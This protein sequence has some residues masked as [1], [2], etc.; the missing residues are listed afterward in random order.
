MFECSLLE[1]FVLP[2]LGLSS[3]VLIT[4]KHRGCLKREGLM[5]FRVEHW[6]KH[7]GG[8]TGE[9]GFGLLCTAQRCWWEVQGL[10]SRGELFGRGPSFSTGS[11][12]C[13]R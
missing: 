8:S 7:Q 3:V 6:G 1:I 5:A 4:V 13:C 10:Q 12:R 2:N 9:G 11:G